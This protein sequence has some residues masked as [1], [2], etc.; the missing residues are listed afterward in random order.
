MVSAIVYKFS[1]DAHIAAC[2]DP[3]CLRQS[4]YKLKKFK[5]GY[6]Y[7]PIDSNQTYVVRNQQ[8]IELG[9][10]ISTFYWSKQYDVY[11]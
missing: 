10:H 5:D 2:F 8:T 7:Y 3:E 9:E 4:G 11:R 1:Y 6:R